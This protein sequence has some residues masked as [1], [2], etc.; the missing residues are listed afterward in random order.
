MTIKSVFSVTNQINQQLRV[1]F[2]NQLIS[3]AIK[4][5]LYCHMRGTPRWDPRVGVFNELISAEAVHTQSLKSC[6][7]TPHSACT[8]QQAKTKGQAK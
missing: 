8:R 5:N 2:S 4:L 1:A 6:V 3:R 7:F